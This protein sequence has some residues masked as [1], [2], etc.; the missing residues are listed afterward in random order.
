MR[1]LV[2]KSKDTALGSAPTEKQVVSLSTLTFQLFEERQFFPSESIITG[3]KDEFVT[4]AID[5]LKKK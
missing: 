5:K 1:R 2:A 3:V 4:K